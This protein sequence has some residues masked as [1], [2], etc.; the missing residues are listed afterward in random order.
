MGSVI[1]PEH[2]VFPPDLESSSAPARSN[3]A[4]AAVRENGASAH[5]LS[6]V[7]AVERH[8][9]FVYQ[10]AHENQRQTAKLLGISRAKLVRHLRSMA[11]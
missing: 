2:V 9:T 11:Q 4:A 3:P 7:K 6:L 1:L 8:I 10:Q 5:D